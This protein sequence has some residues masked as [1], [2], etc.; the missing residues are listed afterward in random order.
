MKA[1]ARLVVALALFALGGCTEEARPAVT[2]AATIV[3]KPESCVPLSQLGETRIRDDWTI[4]FIGNGRVW[5]NA[6]TGRCPGLNSNRR[7][8]YE[9]SLSQLCSTDIIYVLETAAGDLHRGAAC[10]LGQF[11]P[12]KLGVTGGA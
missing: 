11:M 5:R 7:F 9:T 10:G 3:G 8:T 6:L 1:L 2:P 12:V 4:D